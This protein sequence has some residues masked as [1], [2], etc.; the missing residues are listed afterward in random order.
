M[1]RGNSQTKL[2][3]IDEILSWAL[4]KRQVPFRPEDRRLIGIWQKAV[5]P[6]IA[7]QSRPENLRRDVLFVKVS[8]SVWMQQLHFLKGE[9]IEKVNALMEKAPVREIRFS[10]GQ[11][12]AS[13]EKQEAPPLMPLS[14]GLLKERDKKMIETC[15]ASLGD[16]ELKDILKRVMTREIIRRRSMERKY[17]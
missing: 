13:L 15:L 7:A 6:Q 16:Q 12:P 17:P 10:I 14:P 3:R 5:G 11:L 1:G 2:Q 8:T 9:L 4:K